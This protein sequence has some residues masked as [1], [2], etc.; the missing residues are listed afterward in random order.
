MKDPQRPLGATEN[1]ILR[2]IADNHPISV[3]EVAQ[4]V[5]QTTGQA[6]TTVL[7]TM[8][9]LRT[10]GYLTRKRTKGVYRYSPKADKQTLLQGLVKQFVENAL[11]G[12]PSPFIAYLSE[13]GELSQEDLKT[14]KRLV[15][16]VET[17][18]KEDC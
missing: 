12:S 9:R 13:D 14:L 5:A 17:R 3:G 1:E 10:K 8:E 18:R 6:R 11:G 7:T 2:F 4:H 16:E 15:R